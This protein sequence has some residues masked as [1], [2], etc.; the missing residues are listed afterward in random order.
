MF[1]TVQ[2]VESSNDSPTLIIITVQTASFMQDVLDQLPQTYTDNIERKQYD[3]LLAMVNEYAR[4]AEAVGVQDVRVRVIDEGSPKDVILKWAKREEPDLIVLG[5]SR[6]KGFQTR[7]LGSTAEYVV[8]NVKCPVLI[9]KLPR[10]GRRATYMPHSPIAEPT[11]VP[12]QSAS[13]P[14]ASST[15]AMPMPTGS[16]TS[17][18]VPVHGVSFPLASSPPLGQSP[19]SLSTSPNLPFMSSSPPYATEVPSVLGASPPLYTTGV[20]GVANV[21]PGYTI[22][23]G[24]GTPPGF[25]SAFVPHQQQPMTQAQ[26]YTQY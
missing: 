22:V 13:V 3:K 8:R 10:G 7:F 23:S 18:A 9:G 20:P 11:T 17:H 1:H 19:P 14:V 16:S 25:S 12:Q 5:A 26:P 15:L 24:G 2:K 4:R 21:P 6:M